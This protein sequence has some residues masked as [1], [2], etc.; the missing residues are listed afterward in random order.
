[1]SPIAQTLLTIYLT[2]LGVSYFVILSNMIKAPRDEYRCPKWTDATISN[3]VGSF[4]MALFWP[5]IGILILF[6]GPV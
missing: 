6:M 2:G 5:I 3:I 1:M 4:F